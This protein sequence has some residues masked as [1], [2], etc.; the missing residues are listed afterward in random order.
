MKEKGTEQNSRRE[1]GGLQ[2]GSLLVQT[3]GQGKSK[4]MVGEWSPE[5]TKEWTR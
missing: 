1:E 3:G 5:S 4:E 2:L